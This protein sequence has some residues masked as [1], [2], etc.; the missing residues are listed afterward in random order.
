[1]EDFIKKADE[2]LYHAKNAG[3]NRVYGGEAAAG[4]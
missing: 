2:H 4:A 3:K 1:L